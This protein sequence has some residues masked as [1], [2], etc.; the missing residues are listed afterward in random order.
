MYPCIRLYMGGRLGGPR[1]RAQRDE[2]AATDL[3]HLSNYHYHY[4][5]YHYYCHYYHYYYHY[6]C[7]Y[8]YEHAATD[9]DHLR[10]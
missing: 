2:H 9:L 4:Y 5:H 6:H 8:H 7:Y 10:R 3:D 1:A